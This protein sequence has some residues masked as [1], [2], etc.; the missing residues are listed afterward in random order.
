MS[1]HSFNAVVLIL[2]KLFIYGIFPHENYIIKNLLYL[3]LSSRGRI[4]LQ[5]GIY[6]FYNKPNLIF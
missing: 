1:C 5:V 4:Y 6:Y 3:P 2:K